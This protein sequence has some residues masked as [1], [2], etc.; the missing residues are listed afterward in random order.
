[1]SRSATVPPIYGTTADNLIEVSTG[2]NQVF[3]GDSPK[4]ADIALPLEN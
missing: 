2:D 3:A 4:S 1:V